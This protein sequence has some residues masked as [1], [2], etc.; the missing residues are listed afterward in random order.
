MTTDSTSATT[1]A[2][3]IAGG[4]GVSKWITMGGGG[5]Q[6]GTFNSGGLIFD[7][8]TGNY[9]HFIRSRHN[10]SQLFTNAIDF[11]INTS[12]TVN[13]SS[14]PAVGNINAFTIDAT[15]VF[16]LP[17][18]EA[19][20]LDSGALRVSGGASVSKKLYVGT[21]VFIAGNS[22]TTSLTGKQS[23]YSNLTSLSSTIPMLPKLTVNE[24]IDV[25]STSTAQHTIQTSSASDVL[26]I[27]NCANNGYASIVFES[28]TNVQASIGVGGSSVGNSTTDRLYLKSSSIYLD[29]Q[30][31]SYPG[32][33]LTRTLG[34]TV[35]DN[36]TLTAANSVTFTTERSF[37]MF[38]GSVSAY[39]TTTQQGI[40]FQYKIDN[41]TVKSFYFFFNQANI[42]TRLP[43][44]CICTDI[45]PGTHGF[46]ITAAGN[47]SM[48]VN[49]RIDLCFIEY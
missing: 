7:F 3:R 32:G 21:D 20:G 45:S 18:T 1:G 38:T 46:Q 22:V 47:V 28:N 49:S 34:K 4:M 30:D 37:P 29:A 5:E 11:Y 35:F 24:N 10:G 17:T 48:D 16:V 6:G 12:T 23:L 19:T 36:L 43:F 14:A 39:A 13:G 40:T 33:F 15:T 44:S 25:G 27:K 42:H 41:V 2:L 9:K 8:R 26:K 31:I